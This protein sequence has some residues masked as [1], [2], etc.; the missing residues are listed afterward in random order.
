[1]LILRGER[2]PKK[3]NF[4]VK[5]I[6]KVPKNAFFGLFFQNSACGAEILGIIGTKHCFGRARKIYLVDLKKRST[7][8]SKIFWKSPLEK[9][10]DPPLPEALKI[11]PKK[12]FLVIWESSENQFSRPKKQV[13]IIFKFFLK[14]RP[15]PP[16][17]KIL[18]SPLL[19]SIQ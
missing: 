12:T 17:E 2:D 19:C 7:K 15:P 5:V 1:M 3:R 10:L 14:V 16:L 13:D 8:F 6:Q 11:W 9:I 4:S 18:D